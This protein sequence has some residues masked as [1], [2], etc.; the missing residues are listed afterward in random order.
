MIG[1]EGQYLFRFDIADRTDFISESNQGMLTIIEEAGNY[2]P[3]FNLSFKCQDDSII[4]LLNE[5]NELNITFGR[6][7][8]DMYQSKLAVT[9][10]VT[11]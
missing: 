1:V 10:L 11:N 2:L 4:P 3:T 5:R 9:K 7:L 6:T 8:E